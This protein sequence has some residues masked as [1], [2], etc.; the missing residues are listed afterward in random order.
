MSIKGFDLVEHLDR[1]YVFSMC[2]FGPGDRL[3]GNIAHIRKELVEIEANPT[4]VMEW[5]DLILL[6]FD[7]ALR[8]GFEP[9]DIVAA[10][11]VKQ[12][13][14]EHRWWPDFRQVPDGTPIEHIQEAG[15][16]VP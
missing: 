4:D 6:A 11:A 1:Q 8:Q 14:N 15:H 16:V 2:T 5:A 3:A 10:I 13:I 9:A 12:A 7:S